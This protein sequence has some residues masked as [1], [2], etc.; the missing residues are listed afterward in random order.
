VPEEPLAHPDPWGRALEGRTEEEAA[1]L[2]EW[3]AA[4]RRLRREA[5]L[6]PEE[7]VKAASLEVYGP[8]PF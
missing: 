6:L 4:Y 3:V 7:A 2:A 5:K 1:E 8:L